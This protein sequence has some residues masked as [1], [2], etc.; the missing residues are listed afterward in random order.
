MPPPSMSDHLLHRQGLGMANSIVRSGLE[1]FG[2]DAYPPSLEKFV[3]AG[4]KATSSLAEAAT[5][6]DVF[7]LMVVS[8]DQASDILFGP[9]G[10]GHRERLPY[11]CLTLELR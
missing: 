9:N 5:G 3:K 2:Y 6:T 1:V 8:G 4:G 10:V 11:L 7:V